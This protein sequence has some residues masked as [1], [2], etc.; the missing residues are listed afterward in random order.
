MTSRFLPVAVMNRNPYRSMLGFVR[1]EVPRLLPRRPYRRCV[2]CR[3]DAPTT[4]FLLV[5]YQPKAQA[6][7]SSSSAATIYTFSWS[8]PNILK[9]I[10]LLWIKGRGY[11]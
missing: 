3:Y 5:E 4:A 1:Q 2:L 9:L 7:P 6:L 11:L 8:N 10:F